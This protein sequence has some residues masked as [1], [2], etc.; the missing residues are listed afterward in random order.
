VQF[1]KVVVGRD[2]MDRL[3][4]MRMDVDR[5][6][7]ETIPN[8]QRQAALLRQALLE[9][10]CHKASCRKTHQS[11]DRCTCGLETAIQQTRGVAP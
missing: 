5:Y 1:D 6:E 10:G 9:Y 11:E 7:T 2:D 4:M 8:L 3:I